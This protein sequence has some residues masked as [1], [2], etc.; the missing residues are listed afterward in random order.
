MAGKNEVSLEFALSN[1]PPGGKK[2][3]EDELVEMR[4]FI[5]STYVQ[6]D[7]DGG[8]DAKMD[9][10]GDAEGNSA[11]Q[12]F[13]DWI[14]DK[15]EIGEVTGEHIA[16][17]EDV[18]VTTP[19]YVSRVEYGCSVRCCRDELTLDFHCKQRTIRYRDVQGLYAITRKDVRLQDL[20]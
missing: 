3:R 6:Q 8:D 4:L 15:A 1:P 16:I 10:D 19:R 11:A 12:T 17:F 7:A 20:L 9:V 5:P 14:K 18:N 13:H 2:S